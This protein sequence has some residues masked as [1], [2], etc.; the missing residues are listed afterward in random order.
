MRVVQVVEPH[1]GREVLRLRI[2]EVVALIDLDGLGPAKLVTLVE[3]LGLAPDPRRLLGR[4]T[5]GRHEGT[6]AAA[7]VLGRGPL[8]RVG[9]TTNQLE[10]R[11]WPTRTL[12]LH[13]GA[14]RL[15]AISTILAF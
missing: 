3:L 4:R 5:V 11:R 12:S 10:D 6:H 2:R 1:L 13:F 15:R 7:P 8:P 9:L 14:T